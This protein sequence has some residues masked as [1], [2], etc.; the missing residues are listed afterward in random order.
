MRF[1]GLLQKD[2]WLDDV[3]VTTDKHGIITSIEKTKEACADFAIPGF[4]NSHS[5]AFQYAMAGRAENHVNPDDDFWSWRDA[6]YKLALSVNP[7]Q[8]EAIAAMLYSEML[9]HGY[10][11][12]AEFHYLHHDKNG[13]PYNSLAETGARLIS[14]AKYTGINITLVPVYY[15][16]SGFGAAASDHQRRFVFKNIDDYLKLVDASA[17]ACAEYR[18]A[19]IGFGVHSLRAASLE[20]L[21][22]IV[23]NGP[24]NAPFHIHIAEQLKEVEDCVGFHGKRPVECL[25]DRVEL[26]GRFNLVHATYLAE[27]ELLGIARS[28]ANVVIC[29]TTEGNLGDGIFSLKHLNEN[30]GRWSIGTDSHV[31]LNPFEELRLLDY[32]QRLVSRSRNTFGKTGAHF[33]ISKVFEAGSRAMGSEGG[34]Y[35]EIGKPINACLISSD[36]PIAGSASAE[37]RLNTIV[38]SSDETMQKG[39]IVN[40]VNLLTDDRLASIREKFTVVM[41][42]LTV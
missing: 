36:H 7:E 28:G 12:V 30:G 24:L 8:L 1:K 3:E 37:N 15:N 31:S 32:G 27:N 34:E 42:E 29:P 2:G 5:H 25:M 26:D 21:S 11:H 17:Q 16:L 4:L 19:S 13:A 14:A 18:H 40:G 10:T 38:Y 6:M 23:E 22:G 39:T 35:F 41:N 20:D 33:A 9:R